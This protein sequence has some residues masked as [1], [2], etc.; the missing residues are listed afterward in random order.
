MNGDLAGFTTVDS[1][2]A[3]ANMIDPVAQY[4]HDEG[5]SVSGGFVY[6]GREVNELRGS[7]VFGDFSQGFAP[8]AGRLFHLDQDDEIRELLPGGSP[9]GLYVMG[10]GQDRR[11]EIYVLTS[12]NFAPVG[13]TGA[14][15]RLTD[16]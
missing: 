5:I 2:G 11:G 12:E 9:L 13:S 10:F 14:V 4:D 3:P 15:H 16:R 8:P 1:P 7:Y 6:R